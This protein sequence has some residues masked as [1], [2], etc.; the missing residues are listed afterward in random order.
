MKAF[1]LLAFA[2]LLT[3]E[4][5]ASDQFSWLRDDS[6]SGSNVLRYLEQQNNKTHQY[7]ERIQS[8]SESLQKNWYDNRPNRADKPWQEIGGYEY[9]ILERDGKRSLLSRLVGS[10][11]FTE[12]LNIDARS[13]EFDYYQLGAWTL[14]S[15]RTKLA[16]AEDVTGAEQYR[17]SVVDLQTHQVIS[18]AQN[19]D[20]SLAWSKDG[21]S[22]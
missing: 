15:T 22:L 14:D 18:V 3:G 17:V 12:L 5:S 9:A 4:V 6:R 21:L 11:D 2:L 1:V 13:A 20:S 10:E 7:Q 8:L 16:I 19:V